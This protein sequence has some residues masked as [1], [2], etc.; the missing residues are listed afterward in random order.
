MNLDLGGDKAQDGSHLDI[1]LSL[2]NGTD[3]FN[4]VFLLVQKELTT[5]KVKQT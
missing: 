4:K 2:K 3:Y 5:I 1:E